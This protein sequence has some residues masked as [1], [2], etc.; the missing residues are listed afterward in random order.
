[1]SIT[2]IITTAQEGGAKLLQTQAP[3]GFSLSKVQKKDEYEIQTGELTFSSTGEIIL[4]SG[5]KLLPSQFSAKAKWQ[6]ARLI[7]GRKIADLKHEELKKN[8]STEDALT[9]LFQDALRQRRQRILQF[10]VKEVSDKR[11]NNKDATI[12]IVHAVAT[13]KLH[14][15]LSRDEVRQI[16]HDHYTSKGAEYVSTY[17]YSTYLL[18]RVETDLG[19]WKLGLVFDTGAINTDKAIRV[20]AELYIEKCTNLVSFLNFKG[21]KG[22][23]QPINTRILRVTDEGTKERITQALDKINFQTDKI[24]NKIME[25][26]KQKINFEDATKIVLVLGKAYNIGEKVRSWVLR[27]FKKVPEDKKTTFELSMI[28]SNA[29]INPSCPIKSSVKQARASLSTIAGIV[30]AYSNIQEL[31]IQV[32]EKIKE[33][34]TKIKEE[35]Q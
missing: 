20:G 11:S 9:L 34:E 10:F 25:N 3:L 17:G 32:G 13:Q 19:G 14:S 21:F 6:Y 33:M 30:L 29:P 7:L 4:P 23:F 8:Y 16:I 26:G 12:R 15:L 28:L 35:W 27:E 31:I 1:M 18:E 22:D 24:T 2:P 5:E